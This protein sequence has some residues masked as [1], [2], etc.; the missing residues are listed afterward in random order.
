MTDWVLNFAATQGFL[1][2]G[3]CFQWSPALLGLM[4]GSDA[5]ITASYFSIPLALMAFLRA[6]KDIPFNGVFLLFAAFILLCGLTHLVDLFVVWV[7]VYWLQAYAKLSTAIV[8]AATA[9]ALWLLMPKLLRLPSNAQLH[10]LVAKLEHE[11][12]ERR[13]AEQR[14][15]ELNRDLE[16]RVEQRNRE[17]EESLR[18][19]ER[20]MDADRARRVAEEA[21]RAKS[22]LLS[23]M[24]HELRTPL[25]AVLG[26]SQLMVAGGK[27]GELSSQHREWAQQIVRSGNYLLS[28]VDDVLDLARVEARAIE[29]RKEPINLRRVLDDCAAMIMDQAKK[30]Q[31][32]LRIDVPAPAPVVLSDVRRLK[33]VLMN[34]L[35]NAINYNRP[36]GRVDAEVNVRGKELQIRVRDTGPGMTTDQLSQLFTPFNRLGREQERGQGGTGLG[37]V[38][39]KQLVEALGGRISVDSTPGE[40]SEFCVVVP[41]V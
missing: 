4:V 29:L 27:N 24:S 7:P 1:P 39:A 33:Q 26:F 30:R 25:N 16:R 2:H 28:L 10:A 34:L 17:L 22:E 35:T 40:G 19:R 6:R 13:A 9:I 3:Y 18:E 36:G 8:S 38:I 31:V 21:D 23:R 32:S 11:V 37:L 14:L 41:A 20:L 12:A 15:D 5:A